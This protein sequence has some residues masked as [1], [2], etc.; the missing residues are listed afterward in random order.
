MKNQAKYP[1]ADSKAKSATTQ[2]PRTTISTRPIPRHGSQ[3]TSAAS[4]THLSD[5]PSEGEI[6]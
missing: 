2:A 6:K 4:R 1:K 5:L 3:R